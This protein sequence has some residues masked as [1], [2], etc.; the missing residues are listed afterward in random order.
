MDW[1]N[2]ASIKKQFVH[3]LVAELEK[4]E[5]P[6]EWRPRDVIGFVIRKIEEKGK[7]I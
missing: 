4:L 5:L 6:P 1:E 7:K 3:E 2:F